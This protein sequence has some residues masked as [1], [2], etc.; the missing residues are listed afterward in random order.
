MIRYY[1]RVSTEEQNI[2]RQ[3]KAIRNFLKL[4][5]L[6]P[7]YIEYIDRKSGK[8][9]NR[10]QLQAMI[11]DL[12]A[13]D[14]VLVKSL[15]R[16]SR[17]TKD[18]LAIAEQ[19]QNKQ[20]VLMVM[21]KNIDTSDMYGK[22]F[23][24]VVSAIAELERSMINERVKEGVAIAKE[25]GLYKGRHKGAIKLK[26]AEL[27]TFIKDY[28]AGLTKSRL[29]EIYNVPRSTV[30]KWIEVLKERGDID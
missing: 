14:I 9:T 29:A 25:K 26:G 5:G 1:V 7:I 11:Q 3:D 30:Y 8:D 12:K 6:E 19:I 27:K 17:S 21:D 20:A 2:E 4:K 15:D 24:T 16:L 18:L 23:I 10:P 28:K 13:N 22:F